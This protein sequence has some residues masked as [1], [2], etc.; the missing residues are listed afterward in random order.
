MLI[1]TGIILGM[2]SANERRRRIVMSYLIGWACT[3]KDPCQGSYL[4]GLEFYTI[5]IN[6]FIYN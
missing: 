2:G 1:Q 5:R 6:P 3:Q 4:S